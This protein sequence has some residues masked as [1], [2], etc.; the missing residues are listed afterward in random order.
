MI[1]IQNNKFL[2][3]ILLSTTTTTFLTTGATGQ[4]DVPLLPLPLPLPNMDVV[5]RS[6]ETVHEMD[7]HEFPTFRNGKCTI[8]Y[9]RDGN[10]A[11]Q[12]G[13]NVGGWDANGKSLCESS[14]GPS[15][16]TMSYTLQP[17]G[18]FVA[19]CGYQLDYATHSSA[20]GPIDG[21]YFMAIDDDCVLHTYR[22][23]FDC[24]SV[25]IEREIWSNVKREPLQRGDLLR[26]GQYVRDADAK[27]S[28]LMQS[29]DGNL[30]LY[31]D[32]SHG[33][34]EGDVLWAANEEWGEGV[35]ESNRRRFNEFYARIALNGHLTLV[36]IDFD[37]TP[38]ETVYFDKDLHSG[39]ADCFSVEYDSNANGGAGDLVAVS[40][41]GG[42]TRRRRRLRATGS[43][44]GN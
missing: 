30:V 43:S 15:A 21:K 19:Y 17:N 44:G 27:T 8:R 31:Q 3:V 24:N 40:C 35:M 6:G 42:E 20:G 10:W 32:F 41:G 26:Q 11:T 13:F 37:G 1:A 23:T 14:Y 25:S 36:G 2:S 9:P 18:N 16:P 34:P 12:N 39:G 22:G 38:R 4:G 5:L 29:A 7:E 33:S 28:L